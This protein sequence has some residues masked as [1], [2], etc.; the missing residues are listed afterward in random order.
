M[1]GPRPSAREGGGGNEGGP[2]GATWAGEAAEPRN[3]KGREEKEGRPW[4]GPQGKMGER[5]RKRQVGR[6]N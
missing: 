5:K 4:A 2:H 6:P 1:G 3:G